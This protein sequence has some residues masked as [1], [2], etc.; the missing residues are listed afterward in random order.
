MKIW[1]LTL[2][3]LCRLY[4]GVMRLRFTFL[5]T[6]DALPDAGDPEVLA[7]KLPKSIG[8]L[9]EGYKLEFPA[10]TDV[11]FAPVYVEDR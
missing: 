11:A 9:A 10:F 3:E 2:V 7:R 6:F 5:V 8:A 4:P 1:L